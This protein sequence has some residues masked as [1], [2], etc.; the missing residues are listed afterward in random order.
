MVEHDT[1]TIKE[2]DWV[3]DVGP[4]AGKHGGKIMF[5][6]TPTKLLKSKTLTG[7]YLSGKLRVGGVERKKGDKIKTSVKEKANPKA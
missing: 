2:S 7:Q 6:G 1:Q 4:G 5:S 3:I